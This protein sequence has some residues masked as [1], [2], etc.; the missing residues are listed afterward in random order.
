MKSQF[1]S[2]IWT[3]FT[4]TRRSTFNLYFCKR[5]HVL[6][7][8]EERDFSWLKT[9]LFSISNWNVLFHKYKL[10]TGPFS[11]TFEN[12]PF[13]KDK[14][15]M[16]PFSL[17]IWNVPFFQIHFKRAFSQIKWNVPFFVRYVDVFCDFTYSNVILRKNVVNRHFLTHWYLH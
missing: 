14:L 1:C 17:T 2:W 10:E 5:G 9:C 7:V 3:Q 16:R 4:L 8:H 12:V 11:C 15:E 13:Y 6:F